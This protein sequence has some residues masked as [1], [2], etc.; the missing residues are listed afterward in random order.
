MKTY[1]LCFHYIKSTYS[2]LL[3]SYI[4]LYLCFNFFCHSVIKE[5]EK[6]KA[7]DLHELVI[8]INLVYFL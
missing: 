2:G 1:L 8:N 6:E 4:Y 7:V 5:V 3:D